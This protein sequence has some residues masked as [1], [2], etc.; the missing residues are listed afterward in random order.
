MEKADDEIVVIDTA[1]T[2]HTLLLD[3]T[4]SYHQEVQRT[5]GQIPES[6]KKLVT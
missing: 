6:V 5:Q 2:G 3:S 4:L 1:S